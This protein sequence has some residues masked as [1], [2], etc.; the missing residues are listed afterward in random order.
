MKLQEVSAGLV[1]VQLR[2]QCQ[3][4]LVHVHADCMMTAGGIDLKTG[5]WVDIPQG[6]CANVGRT[7]RLNAESQ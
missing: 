3:R 2:M 4:L 5:K 7:A 1:T 6:A